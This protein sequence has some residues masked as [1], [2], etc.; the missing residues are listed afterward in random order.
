[1]FRIIGGVSGI[2]FS[3]LVLNLSPSL[4]TGFMIVFTTLG[5][6]LLGAIPLVFLMPAGRGR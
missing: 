1:M 5:I 3:T 4:N 2:C 6:V